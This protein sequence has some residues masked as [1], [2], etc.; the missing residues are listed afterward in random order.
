[1]AKRIVW[2]QE[3][4]EDF[5]KTLSFY[6]ERNGNK[7]YSK[8]LARET[9]EVIDKLREHPLLGRSSIDKK[10]RILGQGI[11]QI[12]YEIKS[13]SIVILVVWEMRR[14]PE[15]VARYLSELYIWQLYLQNN[16]SII[17]ISKIVNK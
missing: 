3:A 6:A 12:Y 17:S 15:N 11:F 9:L 7:L 10:V 2:S 13:E 4:E 14:D 1:M 16:D 5:N 8:K